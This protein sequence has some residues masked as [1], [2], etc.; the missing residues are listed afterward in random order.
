MFSVLFHSFFFSHWQW[1][2]REKDGQK[3]FEKC[4]KVLKREIERFEVGDV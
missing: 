3:A 4:S 1:E 2:K